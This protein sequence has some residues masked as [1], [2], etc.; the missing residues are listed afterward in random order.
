MRMR[1]TYGLFIALGVL[2]WLLVMLYI[3][4]AMIGT[5]G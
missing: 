1:Y 3:I 2:V 4:G 5:I